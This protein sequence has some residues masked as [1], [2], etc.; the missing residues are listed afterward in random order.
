MNCNIENNFKAI[1]KAAKHTALLFAITVLISSCGSRSKNETVKADAVIEKSN[2]LEVNITEQQF[3]SAQIELGKPEYRNLTSAI[4]SN[5]RL[6]LPPQN[7]ATI[8]T[9]YGGIVQEIKVSTGQQVNKGTVLAIIQNPDII[10]LQQDYLENASH[11]EFMKTD[12]ERQKTLQKDNITSQKHFQETEADYNGTVGK[13]NALKA[14]LQLININTENLKEGKIIP[15][16]TITAPISGYVQDITTNIG[17]FAE[18]N[19]MLFEIINNTDLHIDLQVFEKDVRQINIGQ[20]VTF[21]YTNSGNEKQ[22]DIATVFAIDKEFDPQTQAIVVHAKIQN[23]K[24]IMLPGMYVEARIVID[25]DRAL[26]VPDDAIVSQGDDHFIFIAEGKNKETENNKSESESKEE[27][28]QTG[29]THTFRKIKII[30]GSG[31]MGYIAITSSEQ[32]SEE[33]QIVI[34]GAYALLSEMNKG[35]EEE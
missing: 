2:P 12:Y 31:D 8:S 24:G 20:K 18:P 32:L 30:V 26:A 27:S 33:T 28:E 29:A 25:N 16:L 13:D 14:K 5:G 22:Q 19:S 10:Q 4:K 35:G 6:S 3:K 21:S 9:P 7:K 1:S 34:K 15:N 17:T 11:L 23:P